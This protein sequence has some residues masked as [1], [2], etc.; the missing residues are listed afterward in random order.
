ML[1]FL[2]DDLK[3]WFHLIFLC[4][5]LWNFRLSV[6]PLIS[7]FIVLLLL[8]SVWST[9]S[10]K[11]SLQRQLWRTLLSPIQFEAVICNR[12]RGGRCCRW[13]E[14]FKFPFSFKLSDISNQ[15]TFMPN[16]MYEFQIKSLSKRYENP[17]F[18]PSIPPTL[19]WLFILALSISW[20]YLAAASSEPLFYLFWNNSCSIF[21]T[22]IKVAFVFP[23]L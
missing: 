20:T 16:M 10:S 22:S 23:C 18:L 3:L 21:S 6:F 12:L 17:S 7:C 8:M 19:S 13:T 2:T 14:T 4:F 5:C 9:N 11:I 1:T 15:Q